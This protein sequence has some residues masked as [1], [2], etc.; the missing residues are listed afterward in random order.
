MIF[1]EQKLK[2][3]WLVEPKMIPD[4]RGFFART[5][6]RQEFTARGLN[7]RLAQCSISFNKKKGTLRGMHYQAA[8][9]AEAKL[10]SCIRGVVYDVVIDLRP[11]SPTYREWL[12]VE[13][14]SENYKAL[15]IP[16]GLAHGF[17]TLENNTVVYYQ[18]SEFYRPE[19]ARGVRWNDP[20]FGIVWPEGEKIISA[21]DRQFEDFKG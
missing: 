16:E 3:V 7:P 8:P 15:Y 21:R 2:G 14:S 17:H 10:V 6:C 13:L 9:C 5:W 11:E 12:A 19:C 4:E 18:I 20:A 1:T